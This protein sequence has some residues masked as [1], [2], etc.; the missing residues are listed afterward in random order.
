MVQHTERGRNS[1]TLFSDVINDDTGIC[2]A[3]TGLQSKMRGVGG[4]GG[5]GYKLSYIVVLRCSRFLLK[6]L[7]E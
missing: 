7:S 5:G 2:I 4:K 3:S 6:E 1:K